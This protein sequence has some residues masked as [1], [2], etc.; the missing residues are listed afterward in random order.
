METIYEIPED[1][2]EG[3]CQ[4]CR[5]RQG[6]ENRKVPAAWLGVYAHDKD[7]PCRIMSVSRPNDILGECRS[8][9]PNHIYGICATCKND[10][11][12]EEK[13]Y[14]D[15]DEQPNKRQVFVGQGYKNEAYWGV[16]RLST[17]D[18]YE[19]DS[20]WF[21]FMR[22]EAAEGKIPRNFNPETMKPIGEGF[23][24]T[25]AAIAAWEKVE[26]ALNREKAKAQEARDRKIA[27]DLARASGQIAGQTVMDLGGQ[28]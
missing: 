23:E 17:C 14:C 7:L 6:N 27:E 10:S 13:G 8:F 11:I 15:K 16:H 21:D 1:V 12:F 3:R 25:K 24:E 9:A 28:T 19:P 18:G 26:M 22:R 5:H 2:W 4:W 20:D